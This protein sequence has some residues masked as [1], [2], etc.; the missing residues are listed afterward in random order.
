VERTGIG[1]A[2]K[3]LGGVLFLYEF[4]V[5][6][7]RGRLALYWSEEGVGVVAET[8][9]PAS[10][11]LFGLRKEDLGRRVVEDMSVDE[12]GTKEG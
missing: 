4:S 9:P 10:S 7:C 11:P 5:W 6:K 8:P 2:E 3:T 12:L 1:S